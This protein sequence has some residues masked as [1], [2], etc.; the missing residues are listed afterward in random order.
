VSSLIRHLSKRD[1]W[2]NWLFLVGDWSIIGAAVAV[3]LLEPGLITYLFVLGVIGSRMRALANL[4]H[5]AAHFKLFRSRRLNDVAGRV[6]CASFIFVSYRRYV[7]EHK[8]HHRNLWKNSRDPDLALYELTKT[9]EASSHHSSFARFVVNHVVLVIIPVMPWW[10]L[11]REAQ[12][13]RARLIIVGLVIVIGAVL[14][15]AGPTVVTE[16]VVF[17]WIVPWF[18]SYQ[19]IAYWAEL[20]EHGGLKSYG[21]SWG[22]RNWRGNVLTRWLIGSHSDDLYH[23]LHHWFPAVP[24][25]RLRSLDG[26]CRSQWLEYGY[27]SRCDGF[28]VGNRS[29]TSV[30]RDVWCGGRRDD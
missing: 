2:L 7:A 1:N 12:R 21:W 30:L 19:S 28:F 27:H 15:F 11:F 13:D 10:R 9:V 18:T 20:G 16:V 17:C 3:H 8:M 6:L 14:L 23:L 4:L 26:V 25:H 24:H 5:E 29:G 22:S